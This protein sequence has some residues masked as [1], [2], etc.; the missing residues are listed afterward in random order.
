MSLGNGRVIFTTYRNTK[1]LHYSSDSGKTWQDL[2]NVGT[3]AEGDWFDHVIAIPHGDKT[4]MVG[5]T[6]KGF[7]LRHEFD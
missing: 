3:G 2:G 6:N 1:K 5:G 7:V 4:I